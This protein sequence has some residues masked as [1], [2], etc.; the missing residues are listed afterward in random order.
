M[1][2]PERL[3]RRQGTDPSTLL[4]HFGSTAELLPLW[5]AEPNLPLAPSCAAHTT[6][7][8]GC[9]P[10]TNSPEWP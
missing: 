8:V 7:S 6:G 5:I 3:A 9:G 10:A 1:V 2:D 4:R